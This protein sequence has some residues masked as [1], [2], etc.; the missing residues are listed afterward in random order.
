[1]CITRLLHL[2]TNKICLQKI[3]EKI[4]RSI[5]VIILFLL[6]KV[7]KQQFESW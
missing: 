3:I 2:N 5:K 6:F 7:Y 4:D 1:M